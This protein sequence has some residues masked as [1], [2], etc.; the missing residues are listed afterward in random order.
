MTAFAALRSILYALGFLWLWAWVS[1]SLRQFDS[2]LG[3]ALPVW[4]RTAAF[5]VL[6]AGAALV[7]WCLAAFIVQGRG[8]PAL[9]DAPRRL[10]AAGPYRRVRN[11]MYWGAALMLLGWGLYRE[12][13]A[14]V[15]FVP[16]WWLL[17]HL[18]VVMYEETALRGKFGRDYEEYCRRTPRWIPHH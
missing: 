1:G 18:L 5:P 17:V 8:T 15:L 10:V 14:M 6:I 11:P 2:D 13:P 4:T 7:V 9:F 3:G 12:S 16:V